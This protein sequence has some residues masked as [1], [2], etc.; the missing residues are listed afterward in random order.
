MEGEGR[1]GDIHKYILNPGF[2]LSCQKGSW[3]LYKDHDKT[4][5][6]TNFLLLNTS[7]LPLDMPAKTVMQ[8][9]MLMANYAFVF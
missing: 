5:V 9:E 2:C 1:V 4:V 3:N 8:L 6:Q 7:Q